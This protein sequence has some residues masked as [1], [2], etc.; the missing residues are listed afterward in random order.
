LSR[1]KS[2]VSQNPPQHISIPFNLYGM[3]ITE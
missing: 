1:F 2:I 3:E